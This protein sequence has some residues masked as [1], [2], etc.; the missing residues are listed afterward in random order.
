[1]TGR[2]CSGLRKVTW[3]MGS[4]SSWVSGQGLQLAQLLSVC[5]ELCFSRWARPESQVQAAIYLPVTSSLLPGYR[6]G[7]EMSARFTALP[8]TDASNP[9]FVSFMGSLGRWKSRFAFTYWPSFCPGVILS[10]DQLPP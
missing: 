4:G 1:M 2:R 8:L 10:R 5:L 6:R 9:L 3:D 7:A